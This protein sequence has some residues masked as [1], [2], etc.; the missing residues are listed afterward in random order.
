MNETTYRNY[1][2]VL[3]KVRPS[4]AKA[5]LHLSVFFFLIIGGAYLCQGRGALAYTLGLVLL[6]LGY[7]NSNILLHELGHGS[8]FNG[9]RLNH[10]FGHLLALFPIIPYRPWEL[11]HSQHHRW[12]GNKYQDPTQLDEEYDDLTPGQIKFMNFCWKYWIPVFGVSYSL[13]SFWKPSKLIK[14]FPHAKKDIIFSI[15]TPFIVY[16]P[17]MF[18]FPDFFL[19]TWLPAYYLYMAL[20]EPILLAQHVHV[21]QGHSRYED[22]TKNS[23]YHVKDQDIFSRNLI[24]P[25]WF[26]RWIMLG[27]N[28]HALHHIFPNLPCYE[29]HRVTENFP[30]TVGW[31]EWFKFSKSIPAAI[32]LFKTNKETQLIKDLV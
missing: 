8:F 10:F 4:N 13:R 9:K 23:S 24:F 19:K 21:D 12:S 16:L 31:F 29:Y 17:L 30:N 6:I 15:I 18:F 25:K 11:V 28:Q 27:F 32:L 14:Q 2:G 3:N 20:A 5:I 22:F 1:R 26:S 7:L